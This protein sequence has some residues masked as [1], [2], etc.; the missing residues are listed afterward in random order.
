MR[1]PQELRTRLRR[2]RKAYRMGAVNWWEY[3]MQMWDLLLVHGRAVKL[4]R[5]H[6]GIISE[7]S[8]V[9]TLANEMYRLGVM[10]GNAGRKVKQTDSPVF[11]ISRHREVRDNPDGT[12]STC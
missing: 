8:A 12:R 6:N 2:V 5:Y 10:D 1:D 3:H 11:F 4:N 7:W 9:Q